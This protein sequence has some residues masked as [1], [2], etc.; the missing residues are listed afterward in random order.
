MMMEVGVRP[1]KQSWG[2][3]RRDIWGDEGTL[4]LQGFVGSVSWA[5]GYRYSWDGLLE[6]AVVYL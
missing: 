6:G 2:L 1:G 5:E 4:V 3:A